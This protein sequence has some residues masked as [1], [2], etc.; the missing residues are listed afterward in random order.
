MPYRMLSEL[1]IPPDFAIPT[2]GSCGAADLDEETAAHLSDAI[3]E[4]FGN[5]LRR[6]IRSAVA[7]VCQVTSQRQLEKR[8]GLSQ[9]YL[10]RL[11]QTK[12]TP[13]ATLVALLTLLAH[14]PR[15]RLREIDQ[16]WAEPYPSDRPADTHFC[17]SCRRPYFGRGD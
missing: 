14:A 2:C 17:E 9:G 11:Y 10:S 6:R 4:M 1:E 3:A 5:E 12:A 8:L 13:S 15:Q 16:D 7:K